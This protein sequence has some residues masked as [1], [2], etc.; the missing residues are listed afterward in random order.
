MVLDLLLQLL[1][2]LIELHELLVEVLQVACLRW[3]VLNPRIIE[4][5]HV[6]SSFIW[7]DDLLD[8]LAEVVELVRLCWVRSTDGWL[9]HRLR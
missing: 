8:P 5:F 6:L 9:E 2:H 3:R 4:S 7:K 1:L